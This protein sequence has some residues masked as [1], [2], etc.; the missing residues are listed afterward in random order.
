[1]NPDDLL[2]PAEDPPWTSGKPFTATNVHCSLRW[3]FGKPGENFRCALCGHKFVVGDYV[4]WQF[5]N[6]TPGAGGN[7]FVCKAC[8]LGK[9]KIVNEIL[10]RRAAINGDEWWWF[11]PKGNR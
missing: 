3:S 2:D 6:D 5:T 7:P 10:K 11:I 9:E 1:M 8:D 4:R